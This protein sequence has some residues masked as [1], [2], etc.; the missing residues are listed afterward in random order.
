[1]NPH[2]Q[3][4]V[5]FASPVGFRNSTPSLILDA[6]LT[7]YSNVHF[8][9]LNITEYA[10]NTPIEE[11]ILGGALWNSNYM[12]SHTSD[13]LRYLSLWK[14]QGTY[15]DLDVVMLKPLADMKPNFAGAESNKLIAAGIINF[16]GAT[17]Q[18]IADMCL[19]ELLLNFKGN[20][21]V[22]MIITERI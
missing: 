15:L 18:M 14:Y 1:M 2:H 5:L 17:G 16:E 13:V 4:Y 3:I 20:D 8:Y 10:K 7:H 6:L 11:W 9:Y 19:E 12:I 22:C 21:W